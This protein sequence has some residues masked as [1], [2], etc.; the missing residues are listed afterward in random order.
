MLPYGSIYRRR[1]RMEVYTETV[2]AAVWKHMETVDA[3]VWKHMETVD[4]TVWKHMETVNAAIYGSIWKP[5]TLQSM[6]A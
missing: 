3:T 5:Q 1:Y 2:N 4:A 6:E